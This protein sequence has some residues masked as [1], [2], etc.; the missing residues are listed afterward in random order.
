MLSLIHDPTQALADCQRDITVAADAL[1]QALAAS[2]L[3]IFYRALRA[4]S[5]P[6][7]C[8]HHKDDAAR[9]FPACASIVYQLGGISPAVALAVE[10]HLYVTSAIATFP[11]APATDL[12]RRREAL[13]ARIVARRYL[14]A[15]TNS[16]VHGNLGQLGTSARRTGSSFRIDGTTAYTSLASEADLLVL[17]TELEG[18][19]FAVFAIEPM[20]GHSAIAVGDYLFPNAMIDSDTRPVT[21]RGLELPADGLLATANDEAARLL[22]PF[23]MTWHQ[24]LIAALYLGTAARAID[25]TSAFLRTTL[26]RDGRPLA[27]L[28]GMI[29]DLGR[30]AVA[31]RGA[32]LTLERAGQALGAVRDLPRDAGAIDAAVQLASAAKYSCTATAESIVT[33][34]RGIVGARAFAAGCIL[35][36]LSQEVMFGSLG[37]EVSAVIERRYGKQSLTTPLLP[38]PPYR[39]NHGA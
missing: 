21:F 1:T 23:E 26:G 25:E 24:L 36:R 8:G 11:T 16:K 12:H 34:A 38:A 7:L 15:N 31:H 3:R 4:T 22:F 5:L 19:G 27:D 14:V 17:M 13:L 35:D 37:P 6:F 30:L 2:D 28:D 29:V 33:K 39:T 10:N 9:L 32:M 20:H 18:E